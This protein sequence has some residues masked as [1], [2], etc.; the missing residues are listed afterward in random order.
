MRAK[1][2]KVI[3]ILA[4]IG[5]LANLF[6]LLTTF[7]ALQSGHGY[8]SNPFMRFLFQY[9]LLGYA[10]KLI[11]GAWIFLPLSCCAYGVFNK[12]KVKLKWLV[13]AW[14]VLILVYIWVGVNNLVFSIIIGLHFL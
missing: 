6:D 1:L 7:F 12:L 3:L 5:I 11:F 10:I 13:F 2:R 4:V 9:P 8:E 14:V